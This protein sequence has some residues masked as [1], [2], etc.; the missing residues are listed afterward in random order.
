MKVS[1]L[2]AKRSQ[3][4]AQMQN[5]LKVADEA[6]RDLT[7]DESKQFDDLENQISGLGKQIEVRERAE[8]TAKFMASSDAGETSEK[9]KIAKRVSFSEMFNQMISGRGSFT[10]VLSEINSIGEKEAIVSGAGTTGGAFYLPS[11]MIRNAYDAMTTSGSGDDSSGA[12]ILKTGQIPEVSIVAPVPLYRQ[13]GVTVYDGL[14]NLGVMEVPTLTQAYAAYASESAA[15]STG[16]EPGKAT[17]TPARIGLFEN[18]S[19]ELLTRSSESV[20]QQI[21]GSFVT[22]IDL[23]ITRSLFA[24]VGDLTAMAGYAIPFPYK[25]PSQELLTALW[26]A[27]E[28]G[29]NMAFVTTRTLAALAMAT[30]TTT[31]SG[32][33]L[34]QNG[35]ALG[36]PVYGTS[37]IQSADSKHWYFGD[38][39]KAAIGFWGG[40]E[41]IVNPYSGAKKGQ[42][43]VTVNRIADDVVVNS[44]AFAIATN[45]HTSAGTTTTA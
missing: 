18:F 14:Q 6:K 2:K 4:A 15:Y 30:P 8:E 44:A 22:G 25:V 7:A 5:L 34:I 24:S 27:V 19:K 33:F 10:G 13:L 28:D 42:L 3:L 29:Q 36:Y 43:E 11:Y 1:D 21:L 38:W 16:N 41:I 39:S 31:G 9:L 20:Q 23:G 26:A 40:L 37:I 45:I 17:M 32:V 35:Q 12:N